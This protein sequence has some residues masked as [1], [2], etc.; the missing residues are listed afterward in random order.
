MEKNR[1]HAEARSHG[2]KR[3]SEAIEIPC[4]R[5]F[6]REFAVLWRK[7]PKLAK[8]E[9]AKDNAQCKMVFKT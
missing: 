2:G 8:R 6:L 4:F 3:I 5:E 1:R 7:R 9:I